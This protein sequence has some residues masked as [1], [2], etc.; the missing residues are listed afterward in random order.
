M[1]QSNLKYLKELKDRLNARGFS[2]LHEDYFTLR[3]TLTELLV[4]YEDVS[5]P[6]VKLICQKCGEEAR[7]GNTHN[8]SFKITPH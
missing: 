5:Q 6:H 3:E 1:E 8:R 7:D 4:I 2:W